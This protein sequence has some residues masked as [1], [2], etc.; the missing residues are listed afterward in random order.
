MPRRSE[1]A[2]HVARI[3]SRYK[4]REY[5]SHILRR[6]YRE[7][8]KVK[9]ENLGNVSHLPPAALE[10]LRRALAGETLV[11]AED[12][13]CVERSLPHGH[14]QAVLG[15]LRSLDLERLLSRERCRERDLC[16]AMICQRLIAAG[17]K[18]SV[19]RL[20]SQTTL[21][22]ELELGT[23]SEAEL[24]SAMDWLLERQD[25]VERTL[26]RRHLSHAHGSDMDGFVLYDL[27]SSYL[28]G[29]HCELGA[30]G[31]SRDGVRG[32]HQIVYGL[33][34]SPEGRPVSVRVFEG[35]T[36]DPA[37]LQDAA[38]R[39]KDTFGVKH[40]VFVGDRGMITHARTVELKQLG[41]GFLSSLRAPQIQKLTVAPGYQLS[42]LDETGLCE[43]ESPEF[44]GERLIVCRNPAVAAERARKR[45]ALLEATETELA[46]VK[47]M[48]QN[49]RGR[50]HGAEA[51]KIGERAGRIINQKK[52]AKHFTLTITDGQFAYQRN[53]AQIDEE[54]ALDGIYVIRTDQPAQR[55]G[56]SA[57]VRAYKQLKVNERSFKQM[58]HTLEIRPVHHRLA[59]RVRAHVFLCMLAR[60]VQFELEQ[61]L[62]PMLFTDPAPHSP[63]DP[64]RPAE[65]SR[66]ATHKA[67][68]AGQPSPSEH[69][70]HTLADL[71]SNLATICE[72]TIRIGDTN[73]RIVKH[74]EPTSLQA[75]ALE[76]LGLTTNK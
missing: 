47:N 75:K 30:I 50:L 37:T 65:R 53:Q 68:R 16:V 58:K 56:A 49:P 28:E 13:F 66:S 55:L 72:N 14:V 26:A 71:L 24:L 67:S 6:S 35:N 17:S 54:A 38:E 62:A 15:T 5:E 42:L 76:L 52:M 23:V 1:G 32:K 73:T 70:A 22:S 74:T 46:K 11:S 29:R 61:R 34:C 51:G 57:A 69:P 27:S 21:A 41:V 4:D 45:Q 44:P 3:K 40:V 7:D 60:H 43:I 59:D 36:A 25:R 20:V 33:C 64:T 63:T 10:A 9:H 31:Y 48:V 8:G 18:L 39:V 2:I 12:R 19:T